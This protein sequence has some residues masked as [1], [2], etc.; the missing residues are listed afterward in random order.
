MRELL[1]LVATLTALP[2][3]ADVY[4]WTDKD[5][6]IHYT[7]KPPAP[8]AKPAELPALQTFKPEPVSASP[9][10]AEA[11]VA[12]ASKTATIDI[13]TP[14]AEETIR[15]A[16]GRV[17]VSVTAVPKAGEG[18]VYTLDGVPQNS[19]PTPSTAYLLTGVER[20]EH[21]IGASL[22]DATGKTLATAAP[23]TVYLMPPTARR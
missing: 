7:D 18:I 4:R 16:E 9:A 22:V 3:L 12:K 6:V 14:A 8:G 2:A 23:V 19:V 13:T 15:D 21:H 10:P 11:P 17:P 20:G 1:L 5:G